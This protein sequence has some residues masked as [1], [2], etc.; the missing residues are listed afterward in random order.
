MGFVTG[1]AWASLDT[2]V[3]QVSVA[4]TDAGGTRVA[5]GPPPPGPL[6]PAPGTRAAALLKAAVAEL[7]EYFGGRRKEFSVP[8]DLGSAR[9]NRRTVLSV[10]HDSVRFGQTIT[11]GGLAARAG[12][13]AA[14]APGG[15]SLP[16]ARGGGQIMAANPVALIVPCHRVGARTGLGGG[17]GR[18]AAPAP[19]APRGW[20]GG[21]VGGRA[22]GDPGLGPGGPAPGPAGRRPACLATEGLV[23]RLGLLAGK[24]SSV[25]HRGASPGG[26]PL[27]PP[28]G[29]ASS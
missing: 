25:A 9:G 24:P 10:L 22:P 3:G 20:W 23:A 19:A 29:P 28:G 16:P 18:G 14:A 12:L 6:A 17:G 21:G 2:P 1:L 7:G 27:G 4:C 11:Y 13:D 15:A 26:Q 5:Y 8:V